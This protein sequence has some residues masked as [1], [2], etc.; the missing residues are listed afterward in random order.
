[1]GLVGLHIAHKTQNAPQWIWSTFEH[2][3]N[4]KGPNPSF[5]NP[6]C[7]G[8]KCPPNVQPDDPPDGWNGDPRL[9]YTPPTQVAVPPGSAATILEGSVRINDE[10]RQKLAGMGSV[11]QYYEL[12]STQWPSVPFI[13]GKPAQVLDKATL[14]NQGAGQ[15]PHLL[16]NTTME[17]YLM[18]PDEDINTSSCMACHNKAR[19]GKT[20]PVTKKK[21][22][23]RADFSYLLKDAF[24][25]AA[26]A[27]ASQ[28]LRQE[29]TRAFHQ[30]TS[31]GGQK[32]KAVR[33]NK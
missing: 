24:P 3:D 31:K 26:S 14:G 18:G 6:D 1:M 20:D 5:A 32:T 16:A 17:T 30:D 7:P 27:G 28:Q 19:I 25:A 10:V 21:K 12:V 33:T 8:S 13:N 23:F 4:Y 29:Q 11:W 9:R 15:F 2:V 22:F